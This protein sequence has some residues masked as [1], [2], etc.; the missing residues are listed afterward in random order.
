[1]EMKIDSVP[2]FNIFISF[3]VNLVTTSTLDQNQ[4]AYKI[5]SKLIPGYQ[6]WVFAL[7]VNLQFAALNI[8]L[9]LLKFKE[10]LCF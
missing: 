7:Q 6:I 10:P 4:I 8:L 9:V 1:M 5:L 2:E 3:M